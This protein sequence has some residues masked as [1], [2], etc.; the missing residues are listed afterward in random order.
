MMN[1][2]IYEP[3]TWQTAEQ[4]DRKILQK[5]GSM[6]SYFNRIYDNKKEDDEKIKK[7]EIK[8]KAVIK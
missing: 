8:I 6:D 5:Y 2:D 4:E 3:E 7:G 1:Y